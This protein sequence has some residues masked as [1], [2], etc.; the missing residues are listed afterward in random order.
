MSPYLSDGL[1]LVSLLGIVG[2]NTLGLDPLGLSILLLIVRAKEVDFIVVLLSSRGGSLTTEE[3]LT[4]SAGSR[5][6]GVLSTVRLDV[7]VPPGNSRVGSGV[8][9]GRN[10][11]EDDDVSLGGGVT[12][13]GGILHQ[14][15]RSI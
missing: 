2:S 10:G 3:G 13:V 8:R 11:L 7:L 4:G 15:K 6:I 12:V 14:Q 1:G 5:E 9:G